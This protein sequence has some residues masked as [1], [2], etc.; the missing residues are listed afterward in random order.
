[1]RWAVRVVV[2]GLNRNAY[3]VLMMKPGRSKQFER[4]R[5][6]WEDNIKMI[7]KK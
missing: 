6:R 3:R 4:Q 5:H 7:F 2:M 1:M